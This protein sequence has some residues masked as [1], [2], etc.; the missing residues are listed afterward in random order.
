MIFFSILQ[1]YTS[2]SVPFWSP[3][4][5]RRRVISVSSSSSVWLTKSRMGLDKGMSVF[6]IPLKNGLRRY[7]K[8]LSCSTC[9]MQPDIPADSHSAQGKTNTRRHVD[10]FT[11]CS[12][13]NK[14]STDDFV[15]VESHITGNNLKTFLLSYAV[16][17][18]G[19]KTFH[20]F[21]CLTS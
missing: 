13:W 18:S 3:S 9:G 5:L 7:A 15:N 6:I 1:V 2:T 17:V 16:Q 4:G 8:V 10:F 12:S 19:E 20:K 21:I 11:C 14:R